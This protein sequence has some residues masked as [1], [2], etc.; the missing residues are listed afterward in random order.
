MHFNIKKIGIKSMDIELAKTF[1]DIARSGSFIATAE[2]LHV[3]QTTVTAR[4]KNLEAQLGCQLFVRN[5]A[6]ASLTPEGERFVSYAMQIVQLWGKAKFDVPLPEAKTESISVGGEL[7]LWNPLLLNWISDLRSSYGALAIQVET[8]EASSLIS[9]VS[10]GVLD[11]ALVY[12]PE[13]LPGLKIEL[14]LEEKLVMVSAAIPEPYIYVDWGPVYEQQHDSAFPGKRRAEV[15]ID[16]GLLAL[17]YLLQRSGTGYFRARVVQRYIEEK[18]LFPVPNAPE[19]TYPIYAIYRDSDT[20]A[21]VHKAI[22][23]LRAISQQKI[24]WR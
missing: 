15:S 12:R 5:R 22:E 10:H 24:V 23:N 6:G 17:E 13:Y 14:L 21:T 19:F 9:R 3:T 16:F 18:K 8:G 4:I 7:A 1:L 11:V 2:R 20:S